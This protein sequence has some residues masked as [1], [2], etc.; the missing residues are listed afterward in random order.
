MDF[1]PF[2]Y[3]LQRS[4]CMVIIVADQRTSDCG[5]L[6]NIVMVDLGHRDIEF[7]VQSGE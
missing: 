2:G 7:P 4:L 3:V 1:N 6:P 5:V